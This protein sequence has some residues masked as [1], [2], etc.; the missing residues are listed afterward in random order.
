MKIRYKVLFDNTS[1]KIIMTN[2]ES[3]KVSLYFVPW[4]KKLI[5]KASA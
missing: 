3:L 4:Q 2:M 1:P 5:N